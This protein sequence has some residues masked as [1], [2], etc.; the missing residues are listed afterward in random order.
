MKKRSLCLWI[1]SL[2]GLCA[3]AWPGD[4]ASAT[5]IFVKFRT[6]SELLTAARAAAPA[7]VGASARLSEPRAAALSYLLARSGIVSIKAAKPD[8]GLEP[9]VAGIERLFIAEVGAEA[10]VEST[11]RALAARPDVEYAEPNFEAY[12]TGVQEDAAIRAAAMA[13]GYSGTPNDPWY[14]LQWGL[15]DLGQAVNGVTGIA[16]ADIN[17]PGAWSIT[18]GS[19]GIVLAFLDSGISLT[20][21]EFSGRIVAGYD[22]VNNR[23]EPADDCGHGTGMAS[24]AAATGNNGARM[25]GV[26]WKCST[27]N[28]GARMAGVDWKCRIMPVK[29]LDTNGC[30]TY[31]RLIQG[32]IFAADHGARVINMS[33][34]GTAN[35]SQLKDAVNYAASRGA[36]L[37]A[38]TGNDNSGTPLYPAAYDN[39][40][41][42]GATNSSDRRAAPFSN[43]GI[44]G[45]NYGDHVDFVAPGDFVVG[46]YYSD[47]SR[48]SLWSG[49]SVSASMVSG[50]VA[51]MLG[52]SPNLAF[53]QIYAALK[54]GAHDQVGLASE[55]VQGWDKY[56][57]WGRIEAFKSLLVAQGA[58]FFSHVVV[59]GGF[60]TVF[61][62]LNTGSAPVNGTLYMTREDGRPM[63]A[64]IAAGS[65]V[66]VVSPSAAVTASSIPITVPPGGAR[67]VTAGP[68][69]PADPDI[70]TGWARLETT[71]GLTCGV[72]TYQQA[73]GNALTGIAGVLS[74]TLLDSATIPIDW[75]NSE[76]RYT[77]FAIANPGDEDIYVKIVILRQDGTPERTLAIP[78]LN[79]LRL[80]QQ[81]AR[82]VHQEMLD[83]TG[84]QGSMVLIGENG[85]RFSVVALVFNKD[86][87]AAMP[88]IPSK[89]PG[90]Q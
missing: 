79:P 78:E 80:K 21:E 40:I 56:Y 83:R 49:T 1:L 37:V 60:N 7:L 5:R 22:F 35:A 11:L 75:D 26:D 66:P 16:G 34:G 61:T 28:N 85:K 59:G 55:D 24:I 44:A 51:L 8:A 20:A 82:F 30:T 33:L 32:L 73:T 54:A 68:V 77:G 39:V 25:A 38:S 88:V 86:L 69:N 29:I 67:F 58:I 23:S 90:I 71:G 3:P 9:L 74:S 53:D 42:V 2:L 81:V 15:R 27:G 64:A 14:S 50:V 76:R 62:L 19:D 84:F 17:A 43:P 45:S 12:A 48:V 4:E 31:D 57:G 63:E 87:Y 41:A 13:S 18:T 10:D 47:P 36:I 52:V 70:A 89:A 65:S 46:L 72:G 6:R